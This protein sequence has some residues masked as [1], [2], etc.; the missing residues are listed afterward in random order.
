MANGA[1][2]RIRF[3]TASRPR[4][5]DGA[6]LPSLPWTM[7]SLG[8][9]ILPHMPYLP[10]W[11]TAAFV[12]C[13][14]WRLMIEKRRWA[15]P[16]TWFRALVALFCALGVY[17]AY[18][19]FSGVGPGSALLAM[20]ASLKLL[21]T[22]QLRDQFVLLFIAI[23]LVM[24]SLLRE[25]YLWSLPYMLGA[26]TFIMTAWLRMSAQPGQPVRR[27]FGAAGRLLAYAAPL[28][29]AMWILFPRLSTPFWSVPVDTSSGVSGLSDTM[30]PGDISSLSLSN[31]VAFRVRFEGSVP[32]PRERYWR[33][34]VLHRFNG[35]SW[36]GSDANVGRP[37]SQQLEVS[38]EPYR[39]QVTMEP[40]RQQWLPALD[41]PY[42]WDMPKVHMGRM[43]ALSRARPVDQRIAYE[44]ESY[45]RYRAETD[46]NDYLRGWYLKLPPDKNPETVELARRMRA[47]AGSD[48]AFISAVLDK[49]HEEDFYY[50]LRPPA[51]GR[52]PVD[53]FLFDTKQ[54]FCEHYASAFSVLMRSVGIP[55]RVVIGFQGGE[56]NRGPVGEYMIVRQSDAHAWAEVWF[57]DLGWTRIDP[58]AAVAPERIEL[59][60]AESMFD[61]IGA[62]WGLAAPAAWLHRLTLTWDALNAGWNEWVLGYG[63]DKQDG[64]MQ[65]L[66][67]ESPTWRKLMLT[68]I[69]IVG[70]ITI[71]LSGIMM[72]R[73]RPPRRDRAA[74][75]YDKFVR[76][77]GLPPETGE[78]PDAFAARAAAAGRLSNE[79]IDR[80]TRAY[81]AV[82]YGSAGDTGLAELE[83]AVSS[84]R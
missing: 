67:M 52:D 70:V 35:R 22:R 73:Y 48:R 51:L 80:V 69:A 38:G 9:A 28:A 68:M 2:A 78:T 77:M 37:P 34:L 72:L 83:K 26:L 66:G 5:T 19:T 30:S 39:Y 55:S 75:L 13:G 84:A 71:L 63:P 18:E 1:M 6:L 23:F 14:T 3:K 24:A 58:T 16:P 47:V 53:G 76:R 45:P 49:F 57:E 61:G 12:A 50:T 62:S 54:G 33:A 36:T 59:G 56:L 7:A 10:F 27:S 41:L 20:M 40:T 81:V 21:E 17:F 32:P 44:V 43:Q 65:R 25:Q 42:D 82:R 79:A 64:F 8:V 31:A 60:V 15:L 74:I 11:I 29:L 4:G 46:L